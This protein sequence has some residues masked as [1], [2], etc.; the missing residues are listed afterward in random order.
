MRARTWIVLLIALA[1]AALAG[2]ALGPVSL[3]P[4]TVWS[5]LFGHGDANSVSIVQTLR[6]PRIALDIDRAD[7]V[8]EFLAIPSRS[9][10]RALLDFHNM[11]A[12]SFE[13]AQK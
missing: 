1:V 6:L 3:S 7:D 5:A 2:L 13:E 12:R 11:A 4:G 9:H 10:A 8:T